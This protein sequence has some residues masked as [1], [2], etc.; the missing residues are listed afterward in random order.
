MRIGIVGENLHAAVP[1]DPRIVRP[2]WA[3]PLR[4]DDYGARSARTN[5][6]SV[7]VR[8]C[9]HDGISGTCQTC[10]DICARL[11]QVHSVRADVPDLQEPLFAEGALYGQV[12]LLR[13]RR[14][15]LA[16]LRQAEEKLRGQNARASA[17]AAVVRKDCRV[18]IGETL[19][20]SKTG[21]EVRVEYAC[22]GQGIVARQKEIC[23]ASGAASAE[24]YRQEGRLKTELIRRADVLANKID[25]VSRA[26][27]GGMAAE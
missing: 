16:W 27:G 24:S 10:L 21:Y 17:G 9:K 5:H 12:P 3:I 7:A 19:K 23:E 18:A 8:A 11:T 26:N 6:A 15:K 4:A 2:R 22:L 25:S 14:N 1:V 13:V 20:H